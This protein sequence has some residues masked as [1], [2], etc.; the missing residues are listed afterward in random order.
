MRLSRLAPA[1]SDSEP[2]DKSTRIQVK[3]QIIAFSHLKS[4]FKCKVTQ[5]ELI[6][7]MCSKR[8]ELM[9]KI[10]ISKLLVINNTNQ[11]TKVFQ[12]RFLIRAETM[13][14]VIVVEGCCNRRNIIIPE[15]THNSLTEMSIK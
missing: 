13:V 7:M 6:Q 12:S 15:G 5:E 10:M 14:V 8:Q 9:D 4:V 11:G 1:I 2:S 3:L